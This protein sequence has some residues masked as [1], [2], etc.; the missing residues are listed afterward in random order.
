MTSGRFHTWQS[1][2]WPC[3]AP[4]TEGRSKCPATAKKAKGALSMLIPRTNIF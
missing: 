1:E 4:A 2:S 3:R